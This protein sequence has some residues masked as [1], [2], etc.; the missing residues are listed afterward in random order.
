MSLLSHVHGSNLVRWAKDRPEVLVK[1]LDIEQVRRHA[2]NARVVLCV[3][4]HRQIGG[5]SSAVLHALAA[6]DTPIVPS[7]FAGI[8]LD[9]TFPSGHGT[10]EELMDHYGISAEK[11]AKRA[12]AA[13][14][15]ARS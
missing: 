2:A 8:G 12:R 13:L 5:L 3:E 4:E 1:P 7:R 10:Y 11:L 9:D 6:A 14:C 15:A